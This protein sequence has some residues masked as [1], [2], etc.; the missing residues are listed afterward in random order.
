MGIEI[1]ND[2]PNG[3]GPSADRRGR[4]RMSRRALL[5]L[6]VLFEGGLLVLA[7][8]L[9]RLLGMPLGERLRPTAGQWLLGL[10]ATL[11]LLLALAWALRSERSFVRRLREGIA[12]LVDRALLEARLV[13]L[14]I[15]AVL[16]GLG[17]EALF[18]GILQ[19][20]LAGPLGPWAGNAGAALAFGLAHPISAVYVV[21][22]T[23]VGLYLG[24]LMELGGG[25]LAPVVTHAAYDLIALVWLVSR[26]RRQLRRRPIA[27]AS[28]DP[29]PPPRPTD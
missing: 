18:R 14:V 15:I 6:A 21:Y 13:D 12:E 10:A 1:R 9:G 17:E 26:R 20:L 27:P 22:A 29:D 2:T 3:D 11:P 5:A 24:A 4:R 8:V 19:P 16:A 23:A 7:V 25:L 28:T